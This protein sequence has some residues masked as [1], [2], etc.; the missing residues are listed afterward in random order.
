MKTSQLASET[1]LPEN[2]RNFSYNLD[3]DIAINVATSNSST[4]SVGNGQHSIITLENS[5]TSFLTL[6]EMLLEKIKLGIKNSR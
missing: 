3:E 2:M 4:N 5:Y 1:N 6:Q